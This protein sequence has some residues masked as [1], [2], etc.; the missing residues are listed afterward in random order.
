MPFNIPT[1]VKNNLKQ[2]VMEKVLYAEVVMIRQKYLKNTEEN[3]NKN[4][5]KFKLQGQSVRSQPWFDIDFYR[6]EE[7]FAHLDL[8]S[9]RKYFKG[10]M[11]HKIKIHLK[12]LYFQSSMLKTWR[13]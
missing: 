4:K 5:N 6:I 1:D 10:I 7:N 3:K 12:C 9:I 8:I 2:M 11:K 13:K